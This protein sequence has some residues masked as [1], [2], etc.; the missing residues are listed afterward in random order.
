M[1]C[2]P[3]DHTTD[4]ITIVSGTKPL[5]VAEQFV[6]PSTQPLSQ[7]KIHPKQQQQPTTTTTA[8]KMQNWSAIR[9]RHV[10][11]IPNQQ[12]MSTY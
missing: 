7:K 3:W 10:F 8:A 2:Q 12:K 11:W 1:L 4:L 5:A 6:V 9:P